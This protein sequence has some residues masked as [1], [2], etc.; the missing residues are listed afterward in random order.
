[1]EEHPSTGGG[2][3]CRKMD[4]TIRTARMIDTIDQNRSCVSFTSHQWLA[5]G[6]RT[7]LEP[8]QNRGP[9]R[10][11]IQVQQH[12]DDQ[13]HQPEQTSISHPLP[14]LPLACHMATGA[15]SLLWTIDI[16]PHFDRFPPR[17]R[18]IATGSRDDDRLPTG[19]HPKLLTEINRNHQLVT[20]YFK[21]DILH[22]LPPSLPYRLTRTTP[23]RWL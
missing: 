10:I 23:R 6:V 1:M 11:H 8:W 18:H 15:T 19:R 4:S 16:Q 12:K 17:H 21:L 7:S 9:R 3:S 14:P 2:T 13:K 22:R 20:L 5:I